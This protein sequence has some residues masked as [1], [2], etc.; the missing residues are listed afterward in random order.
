MSISSFPQSSK[1]ACEPSA[2]E[3]SLSCDKFT[4]TLSRYRIVIFTNKEV[5]AIRIITMRTAIHEL[6]P[7]M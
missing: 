6:M 1:N 5:N 7:Q 3:I 4:K 2:N